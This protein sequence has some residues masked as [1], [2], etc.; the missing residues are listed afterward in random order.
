MWDDRV[1][2]AIIRI[3]KEDLMAQKWTRDFADKLKQRNIATKKVEKVIES[4]DAIVLY[5]HRGLRSFGFWHE[6]QK[7]AAI[8][9]PRRPSKWATAFFNDDG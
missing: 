1:V 6:R 2:K 3:A 8:W 7:L 5:R 9:S 4:S